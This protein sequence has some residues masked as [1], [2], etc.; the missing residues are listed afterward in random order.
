MVRIGSLN[1]RHCYRGHLVVEFL[2]SALIVWGYDAVGHGVGHPLLPA[3][4]EGLVDGGAVPVG[5]GRAISAK[6]EPEC[7]LVEVV[8]LG[9]G[10]GDGWL[11]SCASEIGCPARW[12]L[13]WGEENEVVA[14][15]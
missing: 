13:V 14:F 2:E 4:L 10:G 12:R 11:F 15:W 5:P 9:V 8:G 6:V 7:L 1:L 3:L